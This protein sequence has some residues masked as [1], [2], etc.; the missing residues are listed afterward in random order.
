MI[1]LG[2]SVNRHIAFDDHTTVYCVLSDF[3]SAHYAGDAG[4]TGDTGD[5]GDNGDNMA[6]ADKI[7]KNL[8]VFDGRILKNSFDHI[9]PC[10]LPVS[11]FLNHNELSKCYFPL[12]LLSMCHS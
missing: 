2:G 1:C 8:N 12:L 11:N 7:R 6:A 4:D 5:T 10:S 9:L 3:H